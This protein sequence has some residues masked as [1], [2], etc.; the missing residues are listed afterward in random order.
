MSSTNDAPGNRK[1]DSR[2]VCKLQK[3]TISFFMSVCLS[4][5][6]SLLP[7]GTARLPRD[8]FLWNLLLE[9]FFRKSVE[10]IQ[11]SV[12]FD[13]NNRH[14]VCR[15]M[16]IYGNIHSVHLRMRNVSSAYSRQNQNTHFI[17]CTITSSRNS[18]LL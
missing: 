15:H 13:N 9:Y 10:N 4:V 8:E 17:V 14:F 18:C 3:A 12:K 2:R 7:R 1:P 6:P 16:Y 11:F 5:R